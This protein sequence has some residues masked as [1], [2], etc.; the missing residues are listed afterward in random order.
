MS[1]NTKA[2]HLI[3]GIESRLVLDKTSEE[4]LTLLQA[5]DILTNTFGRVNST[6]DEKKEALLEV[7]V[8]LSMS[9][10]RI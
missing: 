3:D 1:Y 4:T 2:L 7:E 6:D 8:L 5:V 9:G 10:V